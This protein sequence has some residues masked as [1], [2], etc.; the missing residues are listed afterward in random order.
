MHNTLENAQI[1]LKRAMF[2]LASFLNLDRK[3]DYRIVFTRSPA[4]MEIPVDVALAKAKEQSVFLGATPEYFGNR[5]ECRIRPRWN[6][7]LI[8]A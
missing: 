4:A 7:V 5:T 2:S 1:A 6:L 3:Y 8:P